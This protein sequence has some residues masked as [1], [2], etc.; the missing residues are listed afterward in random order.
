MTLRSAASRCVAVLAAL[1]GIHG[2]FTAAR[3]QQVVPSTNGFTIGT[4]TGRTSFYLQV[5]RSQANALLQQIKTNVAP[6]S[7]PGGKAVYSIV[8]PLEAFNLVN[9][10]QTK[11][12]GDSTTSIG[13][14]AFTGFNFSVFSQ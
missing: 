4:S 2:A 14:A 7:G 13:G 10:R 6:V 1:L 12:A 5:S 11:S 8:N 3:A 9:E